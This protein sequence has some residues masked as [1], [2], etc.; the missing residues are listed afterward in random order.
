M[1]RLSD[2]QDFLSSFVTIRMSRNVFDG[3][4]LP[5]HL[6][7]LGAEDNVRLIPLLFL[8]TKT[9]IASLNDH[10]KEKQLPS[11]LL[12]H[13]AIFSHEKKHKEDQ[14]HWLKIQPKREFPWARQFHD[15]A[16]RCEER[17]SCTQNVLWKYAQY[18]NRKLTE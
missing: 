8:S 3:S 16:S 12:I 14:R 17:N 15:S 1:W 9:S 7:V 4:I 18:I 5:E 6:V 2:L 13:E 11:F 10:Q